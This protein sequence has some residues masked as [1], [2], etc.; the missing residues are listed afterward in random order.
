[1]PKPH[2]LR[3]SGAT[4]NGKLSS[5]RVLKQVLLHPQ[6]NL[7]LHLLRRLEDKA[8]DMKYSEYATCATCNY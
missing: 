2:A 7:L 3:K 4:A 1:M 6:A 8:M 5:A